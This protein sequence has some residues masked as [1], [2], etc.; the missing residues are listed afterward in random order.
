MAE[1]L[2]LWL[3]P[4]VM[5]V[6][7]LVGVVAT[8]GRVPLWVIAAAVGLCMIALVVGLAMGRA[9]P[10]GPRDPLMSPGS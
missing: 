10:Q 1:F 9:A 5:G 4:V 3:V 8:R 7:W 6:A 2:G